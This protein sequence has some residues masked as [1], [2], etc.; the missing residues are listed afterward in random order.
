[1]RTI[2]IVVGLLIIVGFLSQSVASANY[3][4]RY[5]CRDIT[6]VSQSE[7]DALQALYTAGFGQTWF[8][9]DNPCE[10]GGVQGCVG[11][12]CLAVLGAEK[13]CGPFKITS[14]RL[15]DAQV[16]RVPKE[17]SGLLQLEE[18]AFNN[19]ATYEA[20]GLHAIGALPTL[21]ELSF[22]HNSIRQLPESLGKLQALKVL[23][24][25]QNPTFTAL[26][27]SIGQISN[28]ERLVIQEN[29]SLQSVPASIGNLHSLDRLVIS[30]NQS[31]KSVPGSLH[32]ESFPVARQYWIDVPLDL[33]ETDNEAT[34]ACV[35]PPSGPWPP[36]ATGARIPVDGGD[37]TGAGDC[38]IPP[39]G[40]W[41]PCAR[42]TSQIIVTDS[43]DGTG[44]GVGCEIPPSG[45]WPPCALEGG[46][47]PPTRG[48]CVIPTSGP[49]PQCAR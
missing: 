3:P 35:I 28:L 16:T 43:G 27:A 33:A 49:W 13:T 8:Q 30:R 20:N 7:C 19:V 39:S 10:W 6:E 22:E 1:M 26:P 5:T 15:F 11:Q 40:P 32:R 23:T 9:T 46:S 25:R 31:L 4:Q 42:E 37:G 29:E 47:P 45:P 36:C 18:L 48:D 24:I 44:G 12:V 41:P 17:I 2:L 14:L 34:G 38:V 21:S